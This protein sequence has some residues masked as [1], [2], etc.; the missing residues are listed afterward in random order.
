MCARVHVV[1]SWSS[2]TLNVLEAEYTEYLS[3][4]YHI[5]HMTKYNHYSQS[6]DDDKAI[7]DW[8]KNKTLSYI[9]M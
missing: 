4:G 8:M 1:L 7:M 9:D 3:R 6:D 5:K 2:D